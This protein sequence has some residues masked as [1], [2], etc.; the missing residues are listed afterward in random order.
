M[1]SIKARLSNIEKKLSPP[2]KIDI[3]ERLNAARRRCEHQAML[4]RNNQWETLEEELFQSLQSCLNGA[5]DAFEYLKPY[6]GNNHW[7]GKKHQ[8]AT[9]A[10]LERYIDEL[11][12]CRNKSTSTSRERVCVYSGGIKV[13]ESVIK[14]AEDILHSAS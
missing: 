2:A 13:W 3:V 12:A 5:K 4:R 9:I 7:R 10:S 8:L 14:E 11:I 6:S 1:A